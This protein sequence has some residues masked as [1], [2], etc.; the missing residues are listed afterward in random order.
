MSNK[1]ELIDLLQRLH[2]YMGD[3]ADAD[4]SSEGYEANDEMRLMT[5]IDDMLYALGVEG[6]GSHARAAVD[7]NYKPGNFEMNESVKKI[8]TTFKR[9]I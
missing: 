2:D 4:G 5:D 9:F 6:H 8:Q 3:R 7:V 1:S